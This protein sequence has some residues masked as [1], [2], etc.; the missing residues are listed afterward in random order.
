MRVTDVFIDGMAATVYLDG[1]FAVHDIR[2]L[3]NGIA[4]PSRQIQRKCSCG[5]R[6]NALA[7]FCEHC[8]VQLPKHDGQV[9]FEVAHPLNAATRSEIQEKI[10]RKLKK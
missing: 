5:G 10:L 9:Y 2:V 7:K 8:G 1:S 3:D 4:M 6:C